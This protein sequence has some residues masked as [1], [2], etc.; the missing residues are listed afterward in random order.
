MGVLI[1]VN[2]RAPKPTANTKAALV[3]IRV[4]AGFALIGEQLRKHIRHLHRVGMFQMEHTQFGN[5]RRADIQ[6]SDHV[7][8]RWNEFIR[9]A[10][11]ERVGALVRHCHHAR[12]RG[13]GFA[14]PASVGLVSA[15][16]APRASGKAASAEACEKSGGRIIIVLLSG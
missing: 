7:F 12:G 9:S 4:V 3:L 13:P 6:F 11:D 10:D 15:S 14:V 16:P 5:V 1:R 8:D 2:E